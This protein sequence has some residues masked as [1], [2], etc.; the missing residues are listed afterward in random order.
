LRVA[1]SSR[2][3]VSLLMRGLVLILSFVAIAYVIRATVPSDLVGGTH[4]IDAEVKGKGVAGEIAFIAMGAVF[5]AVGL[6]RQLIC[7]LAGY[8]F[9][10][11]LGTALGVT[12]SVGGCV[13]A[14][15]YARLFGRRLVQSRFPSRVRKLDDFLR[16][17][18]FS[19]ALIIR[20]LPVGSNLLTN[21]VAG[22]SSVRGLPFVLGSAVG[23][24]PQTIVF[25][26][27]GSGVQVESGWQV[28]L[29]IILFVVSSLLGLVIYRR[30][31]RAQLLEETT[32]DPAEGDDSKVS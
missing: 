7:F 6:P 30:S 11:P 3:N 28:G 2:I 18:P 12:A 21:L 13:F 9:G 20:L 29:S 32:A 4:W 14:F 27:A 23:Y 16:D 19:M 17:H 10:L 25:A 8:A 5:T 15:V 31:R 1:N 22:V 24:V 26:L